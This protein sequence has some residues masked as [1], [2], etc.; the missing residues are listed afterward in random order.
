MEC[1]SEAER[2]GRLLVEKLRDNAIGLYDGLANG[3]WKA[4]ALQR[5]QDE[6]AELTPEQRDLV[7]RCLIA[8]V[9]NGLHDFLFALGEAH[10][11]QAGIAIL[12]DGVNIAEQSDGLHGEPFG[13]DG[14]I[15]KF[16]KYPEAT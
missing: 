3:H 7:R 12:V 8:A 16:S 2:F 10:D 1:G 5:L 6:L 15:A 4:P 11:S 13:S 9:D 14:W